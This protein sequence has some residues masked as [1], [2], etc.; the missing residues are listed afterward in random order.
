MC[1]VFTLA[2]HSSVRSLVKVIN[3]TVLLHKHRIQHTPPG[4][5]GWSGVM[6][7]S[8]S[9]TITCRRVFRRLIGTP[10]KCLTATPDK[11]LTVN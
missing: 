8:A 9:L 11:S 2:A 4:D 7:D 5:P 6:T 10:D 1:D 3:N